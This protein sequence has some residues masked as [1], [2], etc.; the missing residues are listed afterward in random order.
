MPTQ[1]HNGEVPSLIRA[2]AEELG[3]ELGDADLSLCEPYLESIEEFVLNLQKPKKEVKKDGGKKQK[4][5]PIEE[6]E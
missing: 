4:D 1:V 6:S 5:D 2:K 3:I